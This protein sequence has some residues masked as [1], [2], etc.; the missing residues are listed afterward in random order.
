[1]AI[2]DAPQPSLD[3][4]N[5]QPTPRSQSD[6]LFNALG[7]MQAPLGSLNREHLE[8]SLGN[9][10]TP[11]A[12]NS[13]S[14]FVKSSLWA[15]GPDL[16]GMAPPP[17]VQRYR[18]QNPWSSLGSMIV[19]Q[20]PFYMFP[21]SAAG[22]G[23]TRSIAPFAKGL[24]I[25]DDLVK[26]GKVFKGGALKDLVKFAPAQIATLAGAA[27]IPEGD[28]S[29]TAERI[30]VDSALLGGFG[31]IAKRLEQSRGA[32]PFVG[33]VGG[34]ELQGAIAQFDEVFKMPLNASPQMQMRILN[35]YKGRAKDDPILAQR[36]GS[37]Q[38][39]LH[40]IEN[41]LTREIVEQTPADQYLRP[42]AGAEGTAQDLAE[43]IFNG[44]V[45]G[46]KN[47]GYWTGDGGFDAGVLPTERV[48]FHAL[49]SST[50][51]EGWQGFVQFPRFLDVSVSKG[52]GKKNLL[53]TLNAKDSA[54]RMVGENDW[55]AREGSEGITAGVRRIK[56]GRG[57][58]GQFQPDSFVA[59]KTTDPEAV[60]KGAHSMM[61]VQDDI[62]R[63]TSSIQ[64]LDKFELA[65]GFTRP[66]LAEGAIDNELHT[67]NEMENLSRLYD[68]A[69][70]SLHQNTAAVN[71]HGIKEVSGALGKYVDGLLPR[72][73][74]AARQESVDM[75]RTLGA[76]L[77]P[78]FAPLT[79]VMNKVPRAVGIMDNWRRGM[80]IGLAKVARKAYGALRP[81]GGK[82]FLSE[83]ILSKNPRL[84]GGIIT[85]FQKLSR[86]PQGKEKLRQIDEI[87]EHAITPEEA[88]QLG[89]YDDDVVKWVTKLDQ[90][91]DAP[92]VA[93]ILAQRQ[94]LGNESAFIPM[95]GHLAMSR[96]WRGDIR[97]PIFQ[98]GTNRQNVTHYASGF[99]PQQAIDEAKAIIAEVNGEAGEEVLE[100]VITKAELGQFGKRATT[101]GQL[102]RGIVA[103]EVML[104]RSNL[105]PQFKSIYQTNRESDVWS[106][107]RNI[108]IN[109]PLAKRVQEARKRILIREPQR[110]KKTRTGAGGF[111]GQAGRGRDREEIA[112]AILGNMTESQRILS[113]EALQATTGKAMQRLRQENFSAFGEVSKRIN[114]MMGVQGTFAKASEDAVD[115]LLAPFLGS[116]V[117]SRAVGKMNQFLYTAT[118]GS[119][120]L[121]FGVLNAMTPIQTVLPELA[122]VMQAVPEQLAGYYGTQLARTSDGIPRAVKFLDPLKFMRKGLKAMGK[123]SDELRE[124]LDRAV[125]EG[126]ISREMVER[127]IG[128]NVE[129]ASKFPNF[130]ETDSIVDWISS[131]GAIPASVTE[132]FS[133]AWSY[134]IGRELAKD[135]FKMTPDLA[136]EFAAKLVNRTNFGYG[137]ADRS[138]ILT[139]FIGSGMGLFKNWTTHYMFNMANYTG[140]AVNKKNY[141][142]LMWS[143]MGT[144]AVGG[145]GAL[146]LYGL[147]N[148]ASRLFSGDS[149]QT[150]VYDA[151]Q[152]VPGG[153]MASDMLMYGLPAALGISLQSRASVPGAD[154]MRDITMMANWVG[155]DRAAAL[156]TMFGGALDNMA[157]GAS[158][159]RD[160]RVKRDFMKAFAPRT[161]NRAWGVW[162]GNLRSQNTGNL[163]LN[164]LSRWEQGLKMVGM[165]PVRVDKYFELSD[166]LHRDVESQRAGIQKAGEW[167]FQGQEDGD[168]VMMNQALL[169]AASRGLP[170]D[171]VLGSAET[172]Y[173]NAHQE[174]VNLKFGVDTAFGL[175]RAQ[176][177]LE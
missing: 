148:G 7:N 3:F 176:G 165:G 110:L 50:F 8:A 100:N 91:I 139:G 14:G 78:I 76:P 114:S 160:D 95:A 11:V 174:M 101:G 55:I 5:T 10:S 66:T 119:F 159:L 161:I 30:A 46:V 53:K 87:W 106:L 22:V 146:P 90:E 93:E 92:M 112:K 151:M 77:K 128:Q 131:V 173:R 104:N 64:D 150:N 149:M 153:E 134:A 115:Q 118:L 109:S 72:K 158:P 169:W 86:G 70:A 37:M 71:E 6:G 17:D 1:M 65:T 170:V 12:E 162:G 44:Q 18:D 27:V 34:E 163:M 73:Y 38:D 166:E 20:A 116:R 54:F 56:G 164:D 63:N 89:R 107:A 59:Y 144:G 142:A 45:L 96:S 141:H 57:P 88:V 85:D 9:R 129:T 52:L 133:R 41:G 21:L 13:F 39:V 98:A 127:F 99:T 138:R 2:G 154:P 171:S 117:A 48:P 177:L 49:L 15:A 42:L 61:K 94:A 121:G 33:R 156:G 83:R 25:A 35:G 4:T 82:T 81:A 36:M 137:T 74:A 40:R 152:D 58:Q 130:R 143:M 167:F 31:G 28:L 140:A 97:L 60:A 132:E 120:D 147:A 29:R 125:T 69:Q 126:V 168:H 84:E 122:F 26:K 79:Q 172:R 108:D 75:L 24:K 145:M 123:P 43:R 32:R 155:F 62:F 111:A 103:E 105:D 175:R 23:L 51:G 19:G 80:D 16:V 124:G 68:P 102:E 113:S 47:R 67:L 135:F 136:H 157:V